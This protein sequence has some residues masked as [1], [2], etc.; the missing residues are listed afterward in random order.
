MSTSQS[1]HPPWFDPRMPRREDCVLKAILDDRAARFPDRRIALFEDGTQWTWRECR[2]QVR[3]QAAALQALG[4]RQGD[5]VIAWL[6]NGPALVRAW[7]AINYLGAIYVPL[8]TA[9]RGATL[10][11]TINACRARLMLAHSALVN[12]LDDLALAHVERV[13]CVG[14]SQLAGSAARRFVFDAD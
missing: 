13:V 1:A 8:N 11:H 3:A 12:R 4:V 14:A 5:R 7:F 2:E 9:Y 6:P 10:E